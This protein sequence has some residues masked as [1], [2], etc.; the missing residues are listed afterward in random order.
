MGKDLDLMIKKAFKIRYEETNYLP[1][2]EVWEKVIK[3]L[4]KQRR[5]DILKRLKP[6]I[7]ACALVVLLSGLFTVFNEPVMALTNKFIKTIV[8]ITDNTIRIHKKVVSIEDK[9]KEDY[10]FGR[11]IEDPRIGE[12]QKKIHFKLLI[13]EYI[14]D[15][16]KLSGV[17]VLNKYEKKETVTML[18]IK[19][20]EEGKK[21]SF[22]IT[23]RS[24][25]N[26][27]EVTMNIQKDE[28][29][30]IEHMNINGIECTLISYDK[31]T[32]ALLWDEGNK[33]GEIAGTISKEDIIKVAKSMK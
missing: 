16:F 4:R 1:S 5:L 2:Q 21:D 6:V 26:D 19:I 7:A 9:D 29:T 20:T 24:F 32:N 27:S 17:D 11:N 8:E 10:F 3:R 15:S 31:T 30:T 25:P 23:Q 33:S 14:P 12:V 22:Q 18:Y 28:N 13:P